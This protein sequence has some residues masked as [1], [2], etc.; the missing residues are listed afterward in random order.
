[1]NLL[2]IKP[3][4]KFIA[5]QWKPLTL[6][7]N[8]SR[9]LITS[10]SGKSL[11]LYGEDG[12]ELHHIELPGYMWA[13]HAVETTRNTYIVS[14]C[15]RSIRDSSSHLHSVT[16]VNVNGRVIRTFNDDI[17]SIH[18]NQPSYLVLD[19][20]HV[21]VADRYNERIILLKSDLRLKR[22]LINELHGKQ[23]ARM[24][25][26]SS[27]LLIVSYYQSTDVEVFEA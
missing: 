17:D 8:S 1:M 6:S 27:R 11:Y 25:L 24:C 16:E 2:S 13:L 21:L 12:N 18:F 19:N 10:Y 23:P 9:L 7:V 4:D 26:T 3:A 5:L 20:D 22:I 14:H 15:N